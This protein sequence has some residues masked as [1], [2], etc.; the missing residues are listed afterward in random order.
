MAGTPANEEG[1]LNAPESRA[2]VPPRGQR[3]ARLPD[4]HGIRPGRTR[5][6]SDIL[7][8]D[9]RERVLTGTARAATRGFEPPDR[10]DAVV[11]GGFRVLHGLVW[12]TANL[13]VERALCL[14]IDD[15]HWSDRASLRFL[16]YLERRLEGLGVLITTAARMDE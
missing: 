3:P 13:A 14:S 10:V 15:L 6:L 7:E 16:A 4:T 1:R 9:G 11:V 2:P 8:P 12:L 5:P